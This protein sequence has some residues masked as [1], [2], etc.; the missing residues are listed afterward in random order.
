MLTKSFVAALEGTDYWQRAAGTKHDV[1]KLLLADLKAA[2][3]RKFVVKMPT[4]RNPSGSCPHAPRT[5]YYHYDE[6][7]AAIFAAGGTIQ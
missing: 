5:N 2:Q 1:V 4:Q 7:H 3:E 6:I